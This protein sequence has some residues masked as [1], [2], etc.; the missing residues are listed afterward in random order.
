MKNLLIAFACLWS[1][2][3]AVSA[4]RAD[5]AA[6]PAPAAKDISCKATDE[7]G[8]SFYDIDNPRMT[9]CMKEVKAAA[10]KAKCVAGVKKA[11]ISYVYAGK[12]PLSMTVFCPR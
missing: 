12:K 2:V 1:T 11:K 9:G 4:A 8:A 6:K 7:S 5:D 10:I 3:S